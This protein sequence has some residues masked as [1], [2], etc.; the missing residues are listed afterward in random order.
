MNNA[1][2]PL[3]AGLDSSALHCTLTFNKSTNTA[4]VQ[5]DYDWIPEGLLPATTL[6]ST[7]VMM[8]E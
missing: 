7:S 8:L 5:L 2:L 3:A 4:T 1:I 6:S